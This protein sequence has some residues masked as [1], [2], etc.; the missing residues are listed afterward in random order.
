MNY[1]LEIC[2]NSAQ[3]VINAE[4]GG[5]HRVELCANLWEAG[6]T[7]STAE[8]KLALIHTSIEIFVLIRPR[9]A[10]FV[11]S[12]LEFEIMKEDIRIAKQ[13]GVHGIVSG[14]LLADGSV[15]VGR[16]KELVELTAPL[17]FTFHRAFD[18]VNDSSRALEDVISCGA[19]RILTSGY[20]STAI[21]G[22]NQL[23]KIQESAKGRIVVMPGGGI[24]PEN[25]IDL[26]N[27]TGCRE[28]H[29][30]GKMLIASR[31]KYKS[32][33]NLNG[34]KD[35]PE[36]KIFVSDSSIISQLKT[37]LDEME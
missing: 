11:Y 23:K 3:S 37:K 25:I 6:T 19:H 33:I 36:H 4:K 12:E 9:G 7:P 30:S 15:D 5:A 26:A 27:E 22:K 29:A 28:F 34:S 14:V 18:V 8:I 16:T 10:D 2:A 31:S 21:E 13:L 24:T 1:K 20:C 35:I 17:P 32:P